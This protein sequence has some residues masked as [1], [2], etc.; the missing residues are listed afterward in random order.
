VIRCASGLVMSNF[1]GV[2]A[3]ESQTELLSLHRW[4]ANGRGGARAIAMSVGPA[5][6]AEPVR[7]CR[8]AIPS[9]VRQS[10]VARPMETTAVGTNCSDYDGCVAAGVSVC[11]CWK[12]THAVFMGCSGR[13]V[14]CRSCSE[15]SGYPICICGADLSPCADDSA[16]GSSTL[17]W[18]RRAR[19]LNTH[20]IR[21][22]RWRSVC[23][24]PA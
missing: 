1:R 3:E 7:R 18:V 14:K 15:Q 6:Q 20:H 23:G 10:S 2:I 19:L 17:F 21:S 22:L 9:A 4:M 16:P 5:C 11:N 12:S 13:S 8:L 24:V